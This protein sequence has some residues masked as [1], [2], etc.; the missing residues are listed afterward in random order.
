PDSEFLVNT[1]QKLAD[2]ELADAIQESQG[3]VWRF[4]QRW[5]RPTAGTGPRAYSGQSGEGRSPTKHDAL[6]VTA[7]ISLSPSRG[8]IWLSGEVLAVLSV[9]IWL[10][11]FFATRAVCRRALLPVTNMARA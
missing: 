9:A 6:A 1:A 5:L 8:V 7:A 2:A 3:Q 10:L 4:S 11:A